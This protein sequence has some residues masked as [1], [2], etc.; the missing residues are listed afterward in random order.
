[1]LIESIYL[2]TPVVSFDCPS[3]P[4]E[5]IQNGVNSYLV[6]YKNIEDL[7]KKLSLVILS[8]FNINQM[9]ITVKKHYPKEI[10]QKYENLIFD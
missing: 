2:G 6:K 9:N 7:K 1:M 10:I 4:S 3:G 5:I 8:K